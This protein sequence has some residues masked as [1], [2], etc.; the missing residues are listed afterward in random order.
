MYVPKEFKSVDFSYNVSTEGTNVG[1]ALVGS[2]LKKD[3]SVK[4]KATNFDP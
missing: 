2:V 3:E 4:D 1:V